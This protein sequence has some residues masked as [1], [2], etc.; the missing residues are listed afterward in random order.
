MVRISDVLGVGVYSS[1][2]RGFIGF[3]GFVG[4]AGFIG[5]AGCRIRFMGL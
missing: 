1:G 3:I 5:F 4:F 2:F